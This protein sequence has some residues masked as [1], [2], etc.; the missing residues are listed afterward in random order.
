MKPR[1]NYFPNARRTQSAHIDS[2]KPFVDLTIEKECG[3]CHFSQPLSNFHAASNKDG[4]TNV[5]KICVRDAGLRRRFGISIEDYN[6]MLEAQGGV[7]YIC[8]GRQVGD[9]T[10]GVDHNHLTGKVRKL[11]C[12]NCNNMIGQSLDN[13]ER[14]RAGAA[15]LEEHNT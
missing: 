8:K 7:C 15:Y 4:R 6:E 1:R 10:M 5:C 12:N 9:L 3:R 11:L 13:P 14:L 2:A